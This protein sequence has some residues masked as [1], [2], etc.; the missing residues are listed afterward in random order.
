MKHTIALEIEKLDFIRYTRE[1]NSVS[2][3]NLNRFASASC[4]FT[5][6]D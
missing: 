1:M 5:P 6:F 2:K 3:N 4:L